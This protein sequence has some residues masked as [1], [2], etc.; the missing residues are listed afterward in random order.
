M[1]KTGAVVDI[2]RISTQTTERLMIEELCPVMNETRNLV[3]ETRWKMDVYAKATRS[4][5]GTFGFVRHDSE[6]NL[7]FPKGTYVFFGKSIYLM[8]SKE[9][10]SITR[11]YL[12]RRLSSISP[13]LWE[14]IS[15]HLG[16]TAP[17][18]YPDRVF[19]RRHANAR[20]LQDFAMDPT[21]SRLYMRVSWFPQC[22]API[23]YDL[24]TDTDIS[25]N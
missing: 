24:S 23:E 14:G 17:F 3:Q 25:N 9:E 13:E 21:T 16:S 4:E 8:V 10:I 12:S 22:K 5:I 20:Y 15:S 11:I 19:E 6:E 18:S 7:V 2:I 1:E